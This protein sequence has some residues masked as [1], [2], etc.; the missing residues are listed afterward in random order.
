LTA[1]DGGRIRRT[2]D[3]GL[4]WD[5]AFVPDGVR[6]E[7]RGLFFLD[8]DD[9]W[10]VGDDGVILRTTNQGQ[11]WI[12]LN[13]G[14]PILTPDPNSF[15]YCQG[16]PAA[17]P[18]GLW[19]IHMINA[20]EGW[21]VGN[22]G[23][24]AWTDN[25]WQS[26]SYPQNFILPCTLFDDA[27]PADIYRIHFF[28]STHGIFIT[29]YGRVYETADGGAK[30]PGIDLRGMMPYC[31]DVAPEDNLEL[32]DIAFEDPG[33]PLADLWVASGVGVNQG[34]ILH[35]KNGSWLQSSTCM[36]FVDPNDPPAGPCVIPTDYGVALLG[37]NNDDPLIVGYGSSIW[38]NDASAMANWDLCACMQ[39]MSCTS[40]EGV[41]VQADNQAPISN[42]PLLGVAKVDSDTACIAG[43]FGV[44]RL[45]TVLPSGQLVFDDVGT[46][47]GRR[48]GGGDFY[49]ATDGCVIVQGHVIRKTTDGGQTFTKIGGATT[50]LGN[51]YVF[52]LEFSPPGGPFAGDVIAGTDDGVYRLDG[53]AWS[54]VGSG[55]PGFRIRSLAFAGGTIQAGTW[56]E[57]IIEF[58]PGTNTWNDFGLADLPVVAFAVHPVSGD[59]IIGTN[60]QGLF[61]SPGAGAGTSTERPPSGTELPDRAVLMPGY[62]N[63]FNPVTTI[64]FELDADTHVRLTIV[65]LLGRTIDTLVD[66]RISAGAHHVTWDAAGRATGTYL[67]RLESDGGTQTRTVVLLK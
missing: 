22:D 51:E 62:P 64:P 11:N 52:A 40:T 8:E 23:A 20:D 9:G 43:R 37:A 10:A 49:S 32:W 50:G 24:L 34:Y 28:D 59:L 60:G 53:G 18:A 14:D 58:D 48:I 44:L 63:P 1:E 61:I 17:I 26:W 38:T 47:D 19:D 12:W 16:V 39:S 35:R 13:E 41:W 7:L 36:Q 45:V 56:G 29:D 2:E 66:R 25:G 42:P 67:I 46:D 6:G 31:P 30:W 3:G 65:D 33:N 54:Q 15:A 27:D 57:G 4:T 21:A 55:S 5:P